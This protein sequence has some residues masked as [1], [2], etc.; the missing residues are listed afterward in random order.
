MQR[1]SINWRIFYEYFIKGC[2]HFGVFFV[3]ILFTLTQFC[4]VY[5]DY[6]IS[7][8]AS[9]EENYNSV[10]Y[11]DLNNSNMTFNFTLHEN[12]A[13]YNPADFRARNFRI[14]SCNF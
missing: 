9:I 8:W 11:F 12:N 3:L 10:T 14:Y 4:I 2:G 13:N 1:G 5:S 6:F 7:K